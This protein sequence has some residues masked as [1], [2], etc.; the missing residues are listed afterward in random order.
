[1]FI[2]ENTSVTVRFYTFNDTMEYPDSIQIKGLDN[3]PFT[4]AYANYVYYYLETSDTSAY[5]WQNKVGET[6]NVELG[7]N[8]G[9]D[10]S[11]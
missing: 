8:V 10:V 3:I 6:V 5:D 2:K 1:M 11:R 4:H 9:I 7:V